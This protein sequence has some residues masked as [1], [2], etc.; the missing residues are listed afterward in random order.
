[1]QQVVRLVAMVDDHRH[2]RRIRGD[3]GERRH[4]EPWTTSPALIVTTVTPDGKCRSASRYSS[5][6]IA[7]RGVYLGVG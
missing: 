7:M 3:R 1:L 2:Q 5:E 6:V 4:G